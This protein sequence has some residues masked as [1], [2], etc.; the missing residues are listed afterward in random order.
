MTEE[1]KE[2][3]F[4]FT[5]LEGLESILEYYLQNPAELMEKREKARSS[6]LRLHDE[7]VLVRNLLTI[8]RSINKSN[9]QR[10]G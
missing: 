5:N 4:I 8:Y 2:T 7:G 10:D 9:S 6:I 1:L 3:G